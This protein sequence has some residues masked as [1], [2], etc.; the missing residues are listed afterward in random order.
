MV[1][2][3][4]FLYCDSRLLLRLTYIFTSLYVSR[5]I[6]KLAAVDIRSDRAAATSLERKTWSEYVVP[7]IMG[8]Q[9]AICILLLSMVILLVVWISLGKVEVVWLVRN[10]NKYST[11]FFNL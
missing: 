10:L 6:V 8:S 3:Y 11:I 4:H 9:I 5:S 7:L 2:I 1:I